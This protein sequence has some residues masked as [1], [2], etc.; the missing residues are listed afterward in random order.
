MALDMAATLV[1]MES[2]LSASGDAVVEIGDPKSP[3]DAQPSGKYPVSI[4][5]DSADVLEVV[6]AGGTIEQHT[7]IV[8][9]YGAFIDTD[10]VVE[11]QL[12]NAVNRLMAKLTSDADLGAKVRHIDIAGIYGITMGVQYGYKDIGG[13]QFRVAEIRV[14]LVV[15]DNQTVGGV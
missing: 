2:L 10:G 1:A 14:P 5:M 9:A 15:D 13:T 6:L 11:Q 12:A 7:V 3:P 4:R 8:T